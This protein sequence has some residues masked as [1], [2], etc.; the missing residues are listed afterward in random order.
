M[1][2]VFNHIIRLLEETAAD[3]KRVKEFTGNDV[4][5]FCGAFVIDVKSWVDE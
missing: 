2:F 1:I 3:G 5:A 4:A